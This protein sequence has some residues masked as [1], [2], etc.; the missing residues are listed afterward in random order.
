M[1]TILTLICNGCNK[2]FQRSLRDHNAYLK[3]GTKNNYCSKS[4]AAR[5]SNA[6]RQ[7][8]KG[9]KK[10]A[11]C[12]DC[13]IDIEIGLHASI[14][15]ARCNNCKKLRRANKAKKLYKIKT[16]IKIK[17]C[18]KCNSKFESKR[19]KFCEQCL[20][21]IRSWKGRKSAEIQKEN[22]KSKGE[23]YFAELCK[24]KFNSILENE[25]IFN[26]WDAD[27]IIPNHK[28]AILY[29]GN[30]HLKKITKKHSVA[31]VQNRDKIKIKEILT[32]G[33]IP[34]IV[35]DKG[36]YDKEF[37]EKEFNKFIEWFEN[38]KYTFSES[39]LEYFDIIGFELEVRLDREIA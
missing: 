26:G 19:G 27:I 7:S 17:N 15:K 11:I 35:I 14:E 9:S 34:Y 4:C 1:A 28:I 25:S 32:S 37:V 24:N 29:N 13:H 20:I 18:I 21:Y 10:K 36:K 3:K 38:N 8:T 16:K 39:T 30:W 5:I 22:R 2:E 6:N 23:S 12:I 33:Y 31:Q